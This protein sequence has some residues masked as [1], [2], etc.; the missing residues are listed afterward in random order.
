MKQKAAQGEKM[1]HAGPA[2]SASDPTQRRGDDLLGSARGWVDS[3]GIEAFAAQREASLRAD[4][5][6][7]WLRAWEPYTTLKDPDPLRACGPRDGA[8]QGA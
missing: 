2:A 4:V 8:E 7:R 5:D 6:E 3:T 1:P